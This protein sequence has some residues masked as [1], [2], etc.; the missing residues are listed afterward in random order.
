[1]EQQEERRSKQSRQQSHLSNRALAGERHRHC[2][3]RYRSPAMPMFNESCGKRREYGKGSSRL[4]P[5]FVLYRPFMLP[6][7]LT[8][9]APNFLI[10]AS[11]RRP[12]HPGHTARLSCS[13]RRM[14]APLS[15]LR[16]IQSPAGHRRPSRRRRRRR[17]PPLTRRYDTTRKERR[18]SAR[19][20]RHAPLQH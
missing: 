5:C 17:R 18:F 10:S 7:R 15:P 13:A 6:L 4:S 11:I 12:W 8:T 3:K 19:T 16:P 1:M 9:T 14:F 2:A 20:R